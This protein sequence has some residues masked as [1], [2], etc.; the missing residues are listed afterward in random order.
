MTA[1]NRDLLLILGIV[2]AIIIS[3]ATWFHNSSSQ[4]GLPIQ[5]PVSPGIY[6]SQIVKKLGKAV[7]SATLMVKQHH[8]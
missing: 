3:I 4:A 6:T 5:S 7:I 8:W 1:S 2:V